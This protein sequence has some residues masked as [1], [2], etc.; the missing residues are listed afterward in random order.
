MEWYVIIGA[1][2]ALSLVGMFIL[3]CPD[4]LPGRRKKKK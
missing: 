1:L 2:L 3:C 4:K